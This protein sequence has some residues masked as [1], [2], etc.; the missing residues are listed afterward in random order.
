MVLVQRFVPGPSREHTDEELPGDWIT[1]GELP[2]EKDI[3]EEGRWRIFEPTKAT[4]TA[5]PKVN[6][7]S[8]NSWSWSHDVE[9]YLEA[10]EMKVRKLRA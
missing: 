3:P 1:V 2:S 6:A 10:G 9:A 7:E 8:P 4:V 5:G